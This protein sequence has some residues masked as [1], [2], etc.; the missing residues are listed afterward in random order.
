LAVPPP[1]T[2][3]ILN[4]GPVQHPIE[5]SNATLATSIPTFAAS[6][7]AAVAAAVAG[8][9]F[10]IIFYNNIPSCKNKNEK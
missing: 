5:L 3:L 1:F 7:A 4:Q 8:S 2:Q 6:A 9:M 10:I